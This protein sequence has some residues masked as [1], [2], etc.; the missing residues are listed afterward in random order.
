[1]ARGERWIGGFRAYQL[2]SEPSG[3]TPLKCSTP[4]STSVFRSVAVHT[5]PRSYS[6]DPPPQSLEPLSKRRSSALSLG[7]R[8]GEGE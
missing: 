3:R 2:W 4:S 5:W 8:I 1:M 6:R 7:D